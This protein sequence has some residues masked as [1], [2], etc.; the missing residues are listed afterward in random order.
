AAGGLSGDAEESAVN[1]ASVLRDGE[2][3]YIPS[4]GEKISENDSG[5][6]GGLVNLNT[7]D[8]ARLQTLP[9]IGESRAADILSYREKNGGFR[10][11]EEIMQVPGIKESIYEKIKDKITTD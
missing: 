5:T 1:L 10:S 6:D 7:A 2:R 3:L 9:G 4:M 8:A 11:V